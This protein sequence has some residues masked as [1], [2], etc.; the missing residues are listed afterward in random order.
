MVHHKKGRFRVISSKIDPKLFADLSKE[1]LRKEIFEDIRYGSELRLVETSLGRL[2]ILICADAIAADD[3][4][5]LP[6]IRRLRPDLLLVVSMSAET[7][8][9]EAFAEEMSRHWIGTIF[10]NAHCILKEAQEARAAREERETAARHIQAFGEP[11]HPEERRLPNLAAWN[12]A[13]YEAEGNPPT[14]GRWRYGHDPECFY[15]KKSEQGPKGWRSLSHDLDRNG[16][17]LLLREDQTLGVVL[18]L[19]VHWQD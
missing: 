17:S 6:L 7:E 1:G 14:L 11:Q 12:L 15:F 2:V 19:G 4:G 8:P 13:L 16:I 18:D 5:Y 10:V 9:F 3:R